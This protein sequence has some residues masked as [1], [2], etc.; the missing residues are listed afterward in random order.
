MCP[1]PQLLSTYMDGELPSP[2]KEKMES[3]LAE[4]SECRERFENFKKL[5][6][7]FKKD[8]RQVRTIVEVEG[9]TTQERIF[10]EPELIEKSKEKVWRSLESKQRF[11]ARTSLWQRRLSI[12]LPAAAA[13][14]LI[15]VFLTAVWFRSGSSGNDRMANQ[16]AEPTS[17]F[18]AADAEEEPGV[19]PIADINSVLQYL[20]SGDT[21]VIILQLPESQSFSRSGEPAI[22]R[23]ADYSQ[24]HNRRRQP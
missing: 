20:G 4:C 23:A 14:A 19:M 2:W 11:R 3:H 5:Q 17:F 15:I 18:L 16:T 10:T 8:T 22:I 6:E 12:P 7:M 1:D 21:N 9:H 13:A 24:T